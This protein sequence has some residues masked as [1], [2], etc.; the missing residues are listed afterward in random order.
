M[1]VTRFLCIDLMHADLLGESQK[2]F[3]RMMAVISDNYDRDFFGWLANEVELTCKAKKLYAP[4]PVKDKSTFGVVIAA[5][6]LIKS[7]QYVN[8]SL[9]AISKKRYY[10]FFPLIW[11]KA[12]SVGY[13]WIEKIDVTNAANLFLRQCAVHDIL[14]RH[15]V[16]AEVLQGLDRESFAI[17]KQGLALYGSKQD[18][19]RSQKNWISPNSHTARHYTL[20]I[21]RFGSLRNT[22]TLLY[23]NM[24]SVFKRKAERHTNG[25]STGEFLFIKVCL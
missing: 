5:L 6:Y 1:D 19:L 4:R 20:M 16:T 14:W 23:E 13:S 7:L 2:H 12:H 11:A 17:Q 8:S 25:I 18:D 9:N 3:L 15:S 24:I 22:S 10:Q 21:S